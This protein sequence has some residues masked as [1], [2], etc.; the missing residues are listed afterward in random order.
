MNISIL[1]ATWHHNLG[2]ELILL[3]E[4][5]YLKNR[6]P[7]ANFYI[8]TY[9]KN[10]SLL[11]KDKNIEYVKYS[12]YNLRKEFLANFKYFWNNVKA[13]IK[14]DLIIIWWWW[15][16]YKKEIQK[17]NSTILQRKIRV[18][19]ARIFFKKIVWLTIGIS[20]PEKNIWELKF[21]FKWKKIFTSTRDKKG[22]KLLEKI[23]VNATLLPD[24]V[25]SYNSKNE[26]LDTW[27][28]LNNKKQIVGISIRHWYLIKEEENIKQITLYLSRKWYTV[29]FLSHSIHQDDKLANDYSLLQNFA[30]K[31]NIQIT[32]TIK[33][34]LEI[35]SKLDYVVWMRFHSLILSVIHN[36][37]F[38]ALSYWVKTDELLKELDY[39][40]YLN[41]WEFQFEDFI[42]KFETLEKM[43]NS[44]K[45]DLKWKC[46]KIKSDFYLNYNNFF[47]GLEKS[48]R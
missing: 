34:T 33:E 29:I 37:P 9:N 10:G 45:F 42:K 39:D 12:P 30:K 41:P 32:K 22:Q 1:T 40:F 8:F 4:Y 24:P 44:E 19:L 35:Y 14:S 13:I 18:L 27:I 46:N 20:Y 17:S 28:S 2:D 36:I 15:L 6:Y 3:Q 11:P 31:Y 16:I 26:K 48:K 25:F 47:D 23:W 43:K 38:V 7:K 5:S 21:L